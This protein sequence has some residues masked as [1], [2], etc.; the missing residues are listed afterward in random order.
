MNFKLQGGPFTITQLDVVKSQ[1]NFL[2]KEYEH[3]YKYKISRVIWYHDNP[4]YVLEFEPLPGNDF[5]GFVGEM[6]VHRETFAVVHARFGFDRAGLKKATPIL[7]KRT[8]PGVNA[9]PSFVEYQVSY[10]KYQDK[11]Q[12]A[13]A[14]TSIKFKI[15]SRRNKINSEFH[16]VSELLVTNIQPTELKRFRREDSF[17]QRDIFVEMI[18]SY[19]PEFWGNFNIIKPDEDLRNAIMDLTSGQN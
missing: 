5:Y 8:P 1:E 13:T 3:M 14:R 12:L 16:S 7:V 9:R 10:Q 11:W 2:S 17:S 19:D 6:Y 4:V 15:R 18:G